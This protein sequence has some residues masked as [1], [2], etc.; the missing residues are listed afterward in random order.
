MVS[1]VRNAVALVGFAGAFGLFAAQP[2]MSPEFKPFV[3]IFA[4]LLFGA[5]WLLV[6]LVNKLFLGVYL[7]G[8][9]LT[10]GQSEAIRQEARKG[11]PLALLSA[12]CFGSV[13]LLTVFLVKEL[14]WSKDSAI[15]T[16]IVALVIMI[17]V[18]HRIRTSH[19]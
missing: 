10:S 15:E 12:L 4:I 6:L 14:G 7:P 5:T 1:Y 9:R 11:Q 19:R 13:G 2:L 16:S 8:P 3:L 18:F 17:F